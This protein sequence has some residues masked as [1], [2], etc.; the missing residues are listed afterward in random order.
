MIDLHSHIFPFIDDGSKSWEM[1]K[2]MLYHA[3]QEGTTEVVWTP[4]VMDGYSAEYKKNI[5]ERFEE[6]KQFVELNRIPIKVHL[7]SEIYLSKE[8]LSFKNEIFGTY[9]GE[10]KTFLVEFPMYDYHP[11]FTLFLSRYVNEGYNI[12]LAHPERYLKLHNNKS[13]YEKIK[14]CGIFIQINAGSIRGDFGEKTKIISKWLLQNQLAALVASDGH[15]DNTRPLGMKS[16]YE[17]VVLWTNHQYAKSLFESTPHFL[18]Y[19]LD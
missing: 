5:L 6:G 9:R 7:G 14:K 17:Q 19:S 18:L 4:H 3:V 15:N 11:N 12:V 1:T 10:K 16:V 2:K 8:L 13:E